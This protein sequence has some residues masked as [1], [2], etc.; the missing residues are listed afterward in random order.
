MNTETEVQIEQTKKVRK[1]S[2]DPGRFVVIFHNDDVTPMDFVIQVLETVF[3]HNEDKAKQLTIKVH[4]E[5]R[6]V[7]GAYTWEVAEQK[8]LETVT[9]ARNN[10]FPLS[11]SVEQ[12]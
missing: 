8:A 5:G 11:V 4:E 7:V 2:K 9:L 3:H 6:A 12:E 1:G 10:G